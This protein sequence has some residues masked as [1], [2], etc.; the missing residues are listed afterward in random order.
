LIPK[1]SQFSPCLLNTSSDEIKQWAT[2]ALSL[3][4]NCFAFSKT[5]LM[6]MAD[7]SVKLHYGLFL[8]FDL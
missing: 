4:F 7:L 1:L 6:F 2:K 3:T 5:W 8:M